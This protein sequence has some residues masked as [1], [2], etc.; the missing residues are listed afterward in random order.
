[1]KCPT[2][3]QT[4]PFIKYFHYFVNPG[5]EN[6]LKLCVVIRWVET[7]CITSWSMGS[8]YDSSVNV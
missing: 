3:I 1:M 7:S 5:I 2:H 8:F 6:K 4:S